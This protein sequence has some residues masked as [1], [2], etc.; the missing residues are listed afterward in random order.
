M[1]STLGFSLIYIPD[2]FYVG[3]KVKKL[4]SG[5]RRALIQV[6]AILIASFVAGG[7]IYTVVD[8]PLF[9]V[10]HPY[11]RRP[12]MFHYIAGE[13]TLAETFAYTFFNACTISGLIVSYNSTKIMGNP[14]RA[15]VQLVLGMTL[16]SIGLVGSHYML[17]LKKISIF[18][19]KQVIG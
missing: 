3:L 10:V 4:L 5:K 18:L 6:A 11:T 16:T 7:G 2:D 8:R 17:H 12:T 9:M 1:R 14:T 13:Q 19:A 15:N